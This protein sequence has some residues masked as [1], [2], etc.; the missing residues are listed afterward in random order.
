MLQNLL[1]R[2]GSY[3]KGVN[4]NT[5]E[6]PLGE[7][8]NLS[9]Q[10]PVLSPMVLYAKGVKHFLV[11]ENDKAKELFNAFFKSTETYLKYSLRYYRAMAY[12]YLASIA[13]NN[14]NSRVALVNI[15]RAKEE[16]KKLKKPT[17]FEAEALYNQFMFESDLQLNNESLQSSYD[18]L[19]V[20][21]T[22]D[23]DLYKAQAH[24][25]IGNYFLNS[26][27][28]AERSKAASHVYDAL[29]YA[30]AGG[31]DKLANSIS[32]NYILV[33]WQQGNRADAI[34]QSEDLFNTYSQQENYTNAEV[35]AN[36][37][38]FM[39]YMEEDYHKAAKYFKRAVDLTERVRKQ[40][41]PKARL[42]LM[43]SNSSSYSG[44]V[45]A[46][47]KTGN[48]AELFEVQE[49]NRSRFLRDQ[50][51]LNS[52][53]ASL[54]DA[55]TLLGNNDVLLYYSLTAP[56]E[57]VIN[58]IT[59]SSSKIYYTY[60][61]DDWI[62]LKK[63]YTDRQKKVPSQFNAFIDKYTNDIADGYFISYANKSQ[64]FNSKDFK[65]VTEWTRQLLESNKPEYT[66]IRNDFLKV[67]YKAT[68]API[69]ELQSKTNVI[70]S[71]SNELNYLPFE[72]FI[73]P[74]GNYFIAS[75]NVKYI[76]SVSV[77]KLLANRKYSPNRKSVFAMGGATYQP[78]G[79]IKG[80]ARTINDF[81]GITET[82][83]TKI[84]N[85]NYN[86]KTEL[87][88]FGFGGA[89]YLAGTLSE[90]QFLKTL[91][92]NARV[93]TGAKMKESYLKQINNSGELT[94]YKAIILSSHGFTSDVIPE[95]SG[96]MM[97]QP[98]EG[99]GNEDTFLLAPEIARFNLK[100]DL[101]VLSACSTGVGA[102]VNGEGINGLNSAFMIGG[103]NST[104]LSLWSV[105]DASTAL[106]MKN[107]FKMR[108]TDG[109]DT[110]TAIN[111]IKRAMAN[112][113]AGE[114]FKKPIYWAPFLLNGLN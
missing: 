26:P 62:G 107:L 41:K 30:K 61:L 54:K 49:L 100:A 87:E 32:N 65:K 7:L 82:I 42:A 97:T 104:L 35:T 83:Q 6:K 17:Q 44:L 102:I 60:V 38:G 12:Y 3:I 34:Q 27:Y 75:H 47:Q 80:T 20:A 43:N 71:A 36:N 93:E 111:N 89:D 84:A 16:I 8:K 11:Y 24:N 48:A 94:N 78:K 99:D 15:K 33:L 69:N 67:W 96:I 4:N 59:N 40:L 79:N 56:G 19:A 55:Q 110:F 22:I 28:P 109:M 25:N 51:K 108:I 13:Y 90:V 76:P 74:N 45:M 63:R 58:V 114:E 77:W 95:F 39:F 37:M 91:D 88:Q 81:Y 68:L 57:V 103:A 50:L 52:T 72:A 5:I 85:G 14:Y 113:E 53:S 21:E 70:I 1:L 73:K 46:L 98:D 105:S 64:N 112:G 101:A 9:V 92:A 23:N 10:N 66:S 2:L 86:L 31:Y 106:T 29:Q 18:L